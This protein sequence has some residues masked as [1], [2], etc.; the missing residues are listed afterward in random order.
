[1]LAFYVT[2]QAEPRQVACPFKRKALPT[3]KHSLPSKLIV[4]P[5][6]PPPAL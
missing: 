5:L 3:P 4:L 2:W 6:N 1:M